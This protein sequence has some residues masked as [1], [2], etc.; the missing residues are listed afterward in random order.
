MRILIGHSICSTSFFEEGIQL[1][2][3]TNKIYILYISSEVAQ[4]FVKSGLVDTNS[5]LC[6]DLVFIVKNF[7]K[8]IF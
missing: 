4:T 7:L 3:K 8:P 1:S 6:I 5:I 2:E